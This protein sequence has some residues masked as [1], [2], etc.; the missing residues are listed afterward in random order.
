MPTELVFI[1][2]ISDNF[3]TE[4]VKKCEKN[5]WKNNLDRQWQRRREAGSWLYV[6]I[7]SIFFNTYNKTLNQRQGG[8]MGNFAQHISGRQID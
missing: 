2:F 5:Y 3:S 6:M 1:W 7:V 4:L 8:W